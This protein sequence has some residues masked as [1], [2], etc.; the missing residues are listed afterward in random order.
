MLP[1]L[2]FTIFIRFQESQ[3]ELWSSNPKL[4]PSPW[5]ISLLALHWYANVVCSVHNLKLVASLNIK[6]AT[7]LPKF[8]ACW[9]V[10]KLWNMHNEIQDT[11]MWEF[12]LQKSNNAWVYN[13]HCICNNLQHWWLMNK[14]KSTRYR[15]MAQKSLGTKAPNLKLL[16][17]G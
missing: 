6:V 17:R 13:G 1:S 12:S 7:N 11:L 14:F 9:I 8:Q 4:T 16:S 5:S 3:P 15:A 2:N 10:N